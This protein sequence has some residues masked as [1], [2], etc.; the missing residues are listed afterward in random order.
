MEVNFHFGGD[1]LGAFPREDILG[2]FRRGPRWAE[3]HD[4]LEDRPVV[5][6]FVVVWDRE[7]VY[8]GIKALFLGLVEAFGE[9]AFEVAV[10]SGKLCKS[11]DGPAAGSAS[12]ACPSA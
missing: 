5:S 10:P 11:L 12:A 8:G 2:V 3:R 6:D 9:V 4:V 7:I 1:D